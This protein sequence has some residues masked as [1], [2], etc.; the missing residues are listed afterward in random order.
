MWRFLAVCVICSMLFLGV[1]GC[2]N[3]R[4]DPGS[5]IPPQSQTITAVL[6]LIG[7][8]IG[9]T[10]LHHH[11]QR[12]GS[13]PGVLLKSPVLTQQLSNPIDIATAPNGLVGVL[14]SGSTSSA[15]QYVAL[16]AGA[17][18]PNSYSLP[19]GYQPT[20]LAIDS[21]GDGWFVDTSGN[22]RECAPP[23]GAGGR[24]LLGVSLSDGLG[25]GQRSIAVSNGWVLIA[26]GNS[27][28]NV[29]Y[30]NFRTDGS[31]R[32]PGS[33]AGS[34]P[35]YPS[36]AAGE[37]ANSLGIATFLLFHTDGTSF[38]ITVPST[39]RKNAFVLTPPPLDAPAGTRDTNGNLLFFGTAGSVGGDYRIDAYD[40]TTTGNIPT[41]ARISIAAAGRTAGQFAVPL[42]ALHVASDSQPVGL[43]PNGVLVIF[44]KF[45]NF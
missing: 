39:A 11:N 20:A 22:V 44:P 14:Q 35:L 38:T 2:S 29:S 37:Q 27:T 36:D 31:Q 23:T 3:Q 42:R 17:G 12:G 41:G 30:V 40:V 21:A 7:L 18:A 5:S 34:R 10:A 8:G 26:L 28:G 43:D 6:A 15:A 33:Y 45:T 32:T 9:L 1:G 16:L 24:C 13:G 4:I 25:T 19:A